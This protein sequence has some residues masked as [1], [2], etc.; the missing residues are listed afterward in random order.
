MTSRGEVQMALRDYRAAAESLGILGKFSIEWGN[1]LAGVQHVL[2]HES[3]ELKA[4]IREK[5]GKTLP[6]AEQ[7]LKVGAATLRAARQSLLRR[8]GLRRSPS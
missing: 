7:H 6:E 3:P 1:T 8:S 4:P 5:I 2:V